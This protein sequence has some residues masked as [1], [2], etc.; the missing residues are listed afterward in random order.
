LITLPSGT[1]TFLFTDVEGSTRR[2]EHLP[3][4]MATA[5]ARH[6][7]L[8]R[9]SI[10][11]HGGTVFKTVGD[12]FCAAFDTAPDAVATAIEAQ[13]ALGHESWDEVGQIRVRMAV[14]VGAAEERDA[15]Y[16]GPPVNR[17]ARLVSAGHGGQV[18]LSL[19]ASELSRDALPPGLAL[20]DLG[21]HR[22]KD[23]DRPEHV[24]DV[25]IPGLPSDFPPLVALDA[26][27][28]NLP[29]ELTPFVGRERE[30]AE[31]RETVL[32]PEVRL[33]TLV[34]PAGVGKTQLAL[35]VGRQLSASFR[36]GVYFVPLASVSDSG[37]V[38]PT[39][40]QALNVSD[41]GT[42]PIVD[43]LRSSIQEREIL[44]LMDNFEHV[45]TAAHV[46]LDLLS[47]CP[48]LKVLVTSRARLRLTGE[49][50]L[51]VPPLAVPR[52]KQSLPQNNLKLTRQSVY[53]SPVLGK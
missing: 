13:R 49:H 5:L 25:L 24:F 33:L 47:A 19:S 2:W 52:N 35:E 12:A 9:E 18:L 11:A 16:F 27:P 8:L 3:E 36:D 50:V 20:R 37:L 30:I 6:D 31:L 44:L 42:R 39:I 15:D 26:R 43:G 34:G 7:R 48:N 10:A 53:S 46:V 21:E 45:T 40:A 4:D 23:L 1:V 22:L 28:N 17:V 32:R 38:A 41:S 51:E 14:H 29:I